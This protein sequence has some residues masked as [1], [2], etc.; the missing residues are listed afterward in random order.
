MTGIGAED[1]PG[2]WLTAAEVAR[3]SRLREDLVERFLPAAQPQENLY[4]RDL[5]SVARFVKVLTDL[6]TPTAAV[7]VA[8]AEL[9]ARPD[10]AFNVA[11]R[12]AGHGSRRRFDSRLNNGLV[13][14]PRT[15][16]VIGVTTAAALLVGGVMA[17]NLSRHDAPATTAAPTPPTPAKPVP[18]EVVASSIR[19]DPG[20]KSAQAFAAAKPDP[21][22]AQW[23]R[24]SAGY[25]GKQQAWAK[26]DHRVA[27]ARW[28]PKQRSVTMAV[29]PVM[30]QEAVDLRRLADESSDPLLT[31][32][33]RAQSR[34]VD[35]YAAKLPKFQPAD[36]AG[37]TA[38]TA[39][40]GAVKAVCS[41][42]R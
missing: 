42:P 27:V 33:L 41:T 28:S 37:W 36:H 11:L 10:A 19:D 40:D 1:V 39:L 13:R 3:S 9:R 21:V 18:A 35:N 6:G 2:H 16:T 26:T 20:A 12:G 31:G 34:Y 7:E 38:A 30:R 17:I 5:V 4:G 15:R 29:I 23:Q 32:L 22:C 25:D 8:V 14:R 24:V